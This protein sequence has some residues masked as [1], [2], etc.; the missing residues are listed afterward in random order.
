MGWGGKAAYPISA[1]PSVRE[2]EASHRHSYLSPPPAGKTPSLCTAIKQ[3]HPFQNPGQCLRSYH[4]RLSRGGLLALAKPPPQQNQH[5][6]PQTH[7]RP[8]L[9]YQQLPINSHRRTLILP[10]VLPQPAAHIPHPLQAIPPIQQILDILRHDAGDVFQLIVKTVEVPRRR[11]G[12]G[13]RL[14]GFGRAL[15]ET[16]EVGEGVRA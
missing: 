10:T 7:K 16:F 12:G 15:K 13:G 2:Y 1:H 9:L 14:V 8:I 3:P 11:V 6:H 5:H 4:P